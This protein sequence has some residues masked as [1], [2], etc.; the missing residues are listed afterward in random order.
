MPQP[1]Q[2]V[3]TP[4]GYLGERPKRTS[5][6]AVLS[7][8]ASPSTP[9]CA[10]PRRRWASEDLHLKVR[11]FA[12]PVNVTLQTNNLERHELVAKVH[13]GSRLFMCTIELRKLVFWSV[14]LLFCVT[15][16]GAFMSDT[17]GAGAPSRHSARQ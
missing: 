1:G 5:S 16:A 6:P 13:V 11:R 14:L 2:R 7:H 12:L 9:L 4:T 15:S 3:M 10:L 8:P 17:G